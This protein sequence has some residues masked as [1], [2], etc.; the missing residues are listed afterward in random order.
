MEPEYMIIRLSLH[1]VFGLS[2]LQYTAYYL[3]YDIGVFDYDFIHSL[4]QAIYGRYQYLFIIFLAQQSGY[5]KFVGAFHCLVEIAPGPAKLVLEFPAERGHLF[6]GLHTAF[7]VLVGK[8][9]KRGTD[10]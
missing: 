2:V 1:Q 3:A 4:L 9:H 5:G 10:I 6:H 8:L 7:R